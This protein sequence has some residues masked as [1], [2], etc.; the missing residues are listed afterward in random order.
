MFK[1]LEV[2]FSIYTYPNSERLQV[3]YHRSFGII[4][5]IMSNSNI[6][7]LIVISFSAI[8]L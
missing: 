4:N 5:I 1:P 8:F 3:E 7:I 2:I 6:C